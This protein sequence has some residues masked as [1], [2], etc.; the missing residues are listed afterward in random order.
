MIFPDSGINTKIT[1]SGTGVN[2][3]VSPNSISFTNSSTVYSFSG[4]AITGATSITLSGGGLVTLSN[5]NSYTGGTKIS[6]GTLQIGQ[7]NALP[8][9]TVVTFG[10]GD[11]QRNSG[12]QRQ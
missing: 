6:S 5:T 12:P 9:A 11:H 4:G 10:S 2:G 8:V 7:T 1:I 3:S